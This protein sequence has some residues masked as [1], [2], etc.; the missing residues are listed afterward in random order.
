M[1]SSVSVPLDDEADTTRIVAAPWDMFLKW[2]K[3][4]WKPGQYI[5]YTR[6]ITLPRVDSS[7]ATA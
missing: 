5:R 2:F 6:P 3:D 7:S 1:R 4:V